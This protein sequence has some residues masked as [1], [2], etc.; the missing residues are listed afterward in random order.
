MHR[1]VVFDLDGTLMPHET[2]SGVLADALG[3][4]GA[5]RALELRYDAAMCR[6]RRSRIGRPRGSRPRVGGRA[7]YAAAGPWIAGLGETLA[8]LAGA[9]CRLLLAT[10][11]WRFVADML[12]ERYPFDAVCGAE[13]AIADATLTGTVDGYFD[14]HDKLGFVACWCAGNGYSLQDVVAIG[15]SRS[16]L[17]LFRHAAAS[18][19]LNA[20]AEARAVARQVIDTD[21]LRDLLPMLVKP[22]GRSRHEAGSSTANIVS[23]AAVARIWPRPRCARAPAVLL[24]GP[25]RHRRSRTHRSRRSA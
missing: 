22:S 14:E 5:Y 21:D 11:A 9:G 13:M 17:P 4:G 12:A 6:T 3:H 18:I 23:T 15:D 20:T 25:P 1:V 10:L 8:V 2:S 7:P 16:D 19:A 24:V